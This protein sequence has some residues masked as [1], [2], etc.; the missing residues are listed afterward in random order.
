M[1]L[2]EKKMK[3]RVTYCTKGGHWKVEKKALLGWH[4]L[5]EGFASQMKAAEWMSIYDD[6]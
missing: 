1:N 6:D 5:K 3:T 2:W 4:V